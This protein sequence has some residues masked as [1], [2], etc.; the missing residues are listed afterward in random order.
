MLARF[1]PTRRLPVDRERSEPVCWSEPVK[2]IVVEDQLHCPGEQPE[3]TCSI[4]TI[5]TE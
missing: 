5:S 1:P 4:Q 3:T 2:N